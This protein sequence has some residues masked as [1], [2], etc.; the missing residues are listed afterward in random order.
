VA[1]F[2]IDTDTGQIATQRQLMHAGIAGED[3]RPARPWHRIKGTHD[4]TTLWYA[5]MRKQTK[6]IFIGALTIR[7]G[8]NHASLLEQDWEEVPPEE[9]RGFGPEAPPL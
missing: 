3:G 7:H 5:V 1:A 4:A 9:I 2:F 8:D 6:G